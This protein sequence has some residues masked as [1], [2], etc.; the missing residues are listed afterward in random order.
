MSFKKLIQPLKD[1]L[2]SKGFDAPLPLQK[3]ILSKIKGGSSLFVTAPKDSGKTTSIIISVIQKL[4]T[5]F[6]DAP[7]A[8]IFVKDKQAALDL[9]LEF[10]AF[11]RGTD[12]RVYCAYD[13]HNIDIQ[14]DEIYNGVDIVIATPKRLNKIF[15]L[16]GINLNKLQMCIVEDAEFLFGN[17]NLAEVTRTPESIGKCQYLVFSDK[18]DA[19]FERWQESFMYN[20]QVIKQ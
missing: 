13:E 15:F 14:R 18:F 5:P 11:K 12:L 8:L 19:R 6:E 9:E 16:N 4:K 17:N 3:E 1:S 20:A 2:K 10:N 7:R